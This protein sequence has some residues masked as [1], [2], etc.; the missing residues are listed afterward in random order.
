MPFL[1]T[2]QRELAPT[3]VHHTIYWFKH[4][5]G[6]VTASLQSCSISDRI[7]SLGRR[8]ALPGPLPSLAKARLLSPN[9]ALPLLAFS[10]HGTVSPLA[11]EAQAR[12]R[13]NAVFGRRAGPV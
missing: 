7:E 4:F 6:G 8:A 1:L 10:S 3:N 13:C 9:I 2:D 11:S 5:P 12:T